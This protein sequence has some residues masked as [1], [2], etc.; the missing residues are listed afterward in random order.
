MNLSD[1][2]SAPM[3]SQITEMLDDGLIIADNKG[4]ILSVNDAAVRFLGQNLVGQNIVDVVIHDDIVRIFALVAEARNSQEMVYKSTDTVSTEF[5][6]RLKP[7]DDNMIA[8]LFLD[9]TLLYQNGSI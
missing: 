3:I 6:L 7:L 8:L 2:A 1:N 4:T 5:A 9:M